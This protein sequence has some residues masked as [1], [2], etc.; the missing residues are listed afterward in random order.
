M[1]NNTKTPKELVDAYFGRVWG[2]SQDID[3]IDELM[4][5]DYAITTA[6]KLISGRANFKAWVKEF[7]QVLL[8]PV[9]ESL[10]VFSNETGSSVVSRFVCS[11]INNGM[12][13][14]PADQK[15]L[16]F[17]GIAIWKI[18]DGRLSECWVERSTVV[19]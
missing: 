1:T 14:L 13:G 16:S 17:T 15:P 5:E 9:N 10:D 18:K 11:G 2:P 3:A 8:N 4:T 12:G 6:G 7:Q 19:L